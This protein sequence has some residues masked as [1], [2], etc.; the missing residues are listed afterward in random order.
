MVQGQQYS[1]VYYRVRLS[2]NDNTSVT[3]WLLQL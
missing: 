2:S 3:L 1:G